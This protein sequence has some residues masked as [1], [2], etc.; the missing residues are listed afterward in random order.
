L[1]P[2]PIP[3][4][5]NV[6]ANENELDYETVNELKEITESREKMRKSLASNLELAISVTPFF[7]IYV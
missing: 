4:Y 1:L 2:L 3:E 5:V 7:G 6:A